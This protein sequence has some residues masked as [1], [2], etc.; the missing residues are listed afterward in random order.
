MTTSLA[1]EFLIWGLIAAAIIAVIAARLRIPYTVALVLGGVALG[2]VPLPLVHT[3]VQ[4]KPDWLTPNVS[5]IVF[6]PALLFE[7]SLK[8]QI[9]SLRENVIPILLF[10]SAGVVVATLIEGFAVHWVLG[11]PLAVAL[12][13]GAAVAATD[14][15]SVL[16]IFK[17]MHADKRL[18]TIVEGES[19]FNDGTAAVLFMILL[20]GVTGGNLSLASGI[21]AFLEVVLGGAALGGGLGYLVSRITARID[22]PQIEITLTTVLAYGSFLGAD[23][24]HVSGV[25]AAVAAGLVVG[26]FGTRYGMRPRTRVALWAFWDYMAFAINSI[27]FLLIGLEVRLEDL[28]KTW[29]AVVIAVAAVVVGRVLSVYALSPASR[30]L[31]YRIPGRWQH[32][33]VWGGLRGALSLALVLSLSRSFPY[34]SEILAMTFGIVAFTI[35]V[36]GLT[37]KPLLGVL[38]LARGGEDAYARARGHQMAVSAARAELEEL[39]EREELSAPAYARLRAELDRRST[40]VESELAAVLERDTTYLDEELRRA[41]QRLLDAEKSSI[42]E[43]AHAGTLSAKTA[44]EMLEEADRQWVELE[45]DDSEP[46]PKPSGS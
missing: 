9:R 3:L 13:F 23:S 1:V 25:I 8:I 20:S 11:L 7:G 12:V 27:V 22:D 37:I 17:E 31:G 6:L 32:V 18:S 14:P 24:L 33:I 29:H 16:A 21:R 42:A 38:G 35:V 34:R 26:N 4:E 44:E 45:S 43:A 2:L 36:Q 19:L 15:I 40:A 41:K 39:R 28:L 10:A 46:P 5:L 30:A